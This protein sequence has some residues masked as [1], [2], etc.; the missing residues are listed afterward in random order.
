MGVKDREFTTV[1]PSPQSPPARG[2]EFIWSITPAIKYLNLKQHMP[3]LD[4]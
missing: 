1:S 3:P 4:V 2:G